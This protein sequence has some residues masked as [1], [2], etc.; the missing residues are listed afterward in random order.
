MDLGVLVVTAEILKVY[1]GFLNDDD[2][3]SVKK[4]MPL[5]DIIELS[6]FLRDFCSYL[7]LEYLDDIYFRRIFISL[8]TV[9]TIL[10]DLLNHFYIRD[11]R[12]AFCPPGFWIKSRDA[13]PASFVEAVALEEDEEESGELDISSPSKGAK[14]NLMRSRFLTLINLPYLIPFEIRLEI[15]RLWIAQDR[16]M[17][18]GVNDQSWVN[19]KIRLRV[20]RDHIF[21]DSFR[22]LKS[23][24]HE[25]KG[26][27]AITFISDQGLEEAG[28]D[29]GGVF[30]E[31]LTCLT[32]CAFDPAFGLFEATETHQL[33][34]SPSFLKEDVQLPYLEFIGRIV[35]KAMYD[36]ILVNFEFASFFL[37]KLLGKR[38]ELDDLLSL[39]KSVYDGLV[40]LKNYI[41]NVENDFGL[42]FT[43]LEEQKGQGTKKVVELIPNGS[44]IAV[45]NDNR[46]NY[47][48]RIAH[49]KLNEKIARQCRAFFQG[50]SDFIDPK[51]LRIFNQRELRMLIS[52]TQSPIDIADM[53]KHTTYAGDFHEYHPTIKRFW[54]SVQEFSD[55]DRRNLVRFITSC[56]RPPLL[57]FKELKPGLCI[58]SSGEEED[59]LPTASTC[60]N[61]LKLPA[62]SSAEVLKSKL[63]YAVRVGAGFELS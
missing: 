12:R 41:G 13:D 36:G 37:A 5:E 45:T 50:L 55:E 14:R 17:S 22:D 63:L 26:R 33:Y 23:L 7:F 58:R 30:K 52:G 54:A 28:I 48:Y 20:R 27:I 61:L 24:K 49:Y 10:S 46:I 42:N 62:Y 2:F 39:D 6:G 8:G 19:P 16:E 31:F 44:N 1:L 53:Q 38:N 56:P 34:P 35:G 32:D 59:R 60:I 21:E 4:F 47:I 15:L 51:W 3:L 11:S 9:R 29:G 57:G 18:L 40:F 43:V 25:L